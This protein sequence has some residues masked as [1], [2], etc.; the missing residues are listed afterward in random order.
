MADKRGHNAG[1]ALYVYYALSSY[2]AIADSTLAKIYWFNLVPFI[3]IHVFTG[4]LSELRLSS[5]STC[6][7]QT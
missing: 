3:I 2:L 4:D 5:Y 6:I 1:I 7:G